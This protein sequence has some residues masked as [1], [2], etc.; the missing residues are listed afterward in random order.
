MSD[1]AVYGIVET[2]PAGR[3]GGVRR[4]PGT[5][6]PAAGSLDHR[7]TGEKRRVSEFRGVLES[8]HERRSDRG[9][10]APADRTRASGSEVRT[11][12]TRG[13]LPVDLV[14]AAFNAGMACV[15]AAAAAGVGA[16]PPAVAPWLAAAHAAAAALPWALRD[17]WKIPWRPCLLLREIYPLFGIAV[18][19]AEL[20]L[21]ARAR[22]LPA[23]DGL[24]AAWD[25]A[26]F[27]VHLHAIWEPAAPWPWLREAM[28]FFYFSYYVMLIIPAVVIIARGRRDAVRDATLRLMA[29]YLSCFLF[30]ACFPVHGPRVSDPVPVS[31][32]HAGF[33]E[34]VV[35]R[36]RETGDS[37]GTA[38]PSSHVA[39]MVA[40]AWFGRR[41]FRRRTAAALALGALLVALATVYTGNHFAVDALTGALWGVAVQVIVTAASGRNPGYGEWDRSSGGGTRD[42]GSLGRNP[43]TRGRPRVSAEPH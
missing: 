37:P 16:P 40:V 15:W 1:Y 27:G 30:Y 28:Y 42:G 2:I 3:W 19:W 12:V 33:F 24:V 6:V 35:E 9:G 22:P 10:T 11:T 4:R 29:T 26:L 43:W 5:C 20:G 31:A 38:F 17:R 32:H 39:G 25:R 8:G 18:F 23:H 34:S 41:W 21:L 36:A 13:L 7:R 14:V